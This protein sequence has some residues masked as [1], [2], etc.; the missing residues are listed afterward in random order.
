MQR[1]YL[2]LF[3]LFFYIRI[4]FAWFLLSNNNNVTT[5]VSMS[6]RMMR[7][8]KEAKA[9]ILYRSSFDYMAIPYP[10]KEPVFLHLLPN[11]TSQKTAHAL[12]ITRSFMGFL[13][14]RRLFQSRFDFQRFALCLFYYLS[15]EILLKKKM[16]SSFCS[17]WQH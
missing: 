3:F 16:F 4:N 11:L 8:V 6:V 2:F 9:A 7:K 14:K 1:I 12:A 13:E 10:L 5:Q 17:D 15:S